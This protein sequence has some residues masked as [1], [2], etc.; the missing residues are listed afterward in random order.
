MTVPAWIL[1]CL[2]CSSVGVLLGGLCGHLSRARLSEENDDLRLKLGQANAKL[3]E[4]YP[5][6]NA[7]PKCIDTEQFHVAGTATDRLARV[8]DGLADCRGGIGR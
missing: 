7:R 8:R 6:Y 5:A 4:V 2:G 1:I 3:D